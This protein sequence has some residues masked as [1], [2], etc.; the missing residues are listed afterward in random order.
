MTARKFPTVVKTI[1]EVA[2]YFGVNR[3]TVHEWRLRGMPVDSGGYDVAAIA[4][5]IERESSKLAEPA[6][7][8]LEGATP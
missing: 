4:T 5:W 6:C 1:G 3:R 7:F 2:D 8:Q